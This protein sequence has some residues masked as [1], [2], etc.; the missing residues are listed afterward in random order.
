MP[1]RSWPR[2]QPRPTPIRPTSRSRSPAPEF[3]GG[4]Q[5]TF[6][7]TADVDC[8][9]TVTYTDGRAAGQPATQSGEGESFS[10]SY[11]TKT[12]TKIFKS[13][14]TATCAYDDGSAESSSWTEPAAATASASATVT[15]LPVGSDAGDDDSEAGA[16]G[17]DDNG[18]LPDTGGSNL[19]LFA[20]GGGLVIV[21]AG[22]VIAARRRHAST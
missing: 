13:P 8:D 19:W 6:S 18:V 21:G 16:G 14:I 10:G 3:V 22:A 7:A 15:L 1:S 12:V 5:F 9:W 4:N 17:G 2:A 11:E 20:V